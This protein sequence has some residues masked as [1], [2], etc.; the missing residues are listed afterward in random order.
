M[1]RLLTT[2]A[3]V[4]PAILAA[5]FTLL[6][7]LGAPSSASAAMTVHDVAPPIAT[8]GSF[9]G[10]IVSSVIGGV[11]WTVNLAGSFILNLIGGLVKL[12]IPRS[13]IHQ[14]L[15]ILQWV[16]AVPDYTGKVT[17][18]GGRHV[19]GFPG[20]NAMRGL[21][22][23]L[24]LA[25]L[26]LTA[27]YAG[28]RAWTG[29][30]DHV[31]M[32]LVRVVTVSI[33]VL[34]YTWLWGQAVA[35]ANQFTT[36]IL[37]VRAVTQGI[38][39]MFTLLVSGTVLVG[40][41]LIGEV[42]LAA[43]AAGLLAMIFL[44]VVLILVGALVYAIGPLMIGLAPTERGHA[45]AR[46]WAS[47]AIALFVIGILWASL[48]ALAAVLLNDASSGALLLGGSSSAGHLL[49]GVVI[50]MA[51]IAGF[52]ANIKLTKAI[53]GIIAG[54]LSGV[55]A[56]L[57]G[58][59]LHG[60][61]GRGAAPGA[62]PSPGGGGATSLRGFAAKLGGGLAGAAGSVVPAGRA[63]AIL[64][65]GAGAGGTLARG[66]LIGAGGALAGRGLAGAAHTNLARAAG[67]TRAGA[68]ATRLAR[69]GQRG[70]KAAAASVA[71]GGALGVVGGATAANT[72]RR[73]AGT[74]PTPPSNGNPTPP[75]ETSQTPPRPGGGPPPAGGGPRS[76]IPPVVPPAPAARPTR[77]T[78]APLPS[79]TQTSPATPGRPGGGSAAPPPRS[80][81]TPPSP[82]TSPFA[83]RSTP[84]PTRSM[85][86]LR[87]GRKP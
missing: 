87:K 2:R 50:A 52:Y 14:G 12:L 60:V 72:A 56:Q 43:A 18:P 69:G 57:G 13:W 42:L 71:A 9:L 79:S 45:I 29:Q 44:K 39:K 1:R 34:S 47:L 64:T 21:Y 73:A 83:Q 74:S 51:A 26:P 15:Q 40:L 31:A 28:S 58:R 25:I 77:Q 67:A 66:G 68:V 16:V 19:Y 54:Q 38:Y 4:T 17:A 8:V 35:L 85:P 78:G 10:G 63:G 81:T 65:A 30:G 22:T 84:K 23:W 5:G 53:A 41:P 27:L 86:R 80:S 62:T 7:L 36:A 55:L 48:F 61:L 24:G 6:V 11:S 59:G 46:A 82:A 70:W 20:V 3:G 33:G 49:S 32:P 75:P 76:P 37:G